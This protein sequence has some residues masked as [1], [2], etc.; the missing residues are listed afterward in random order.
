MGAGLIPSSAPDAENRPVLRFIAAREFGMLEPALDVLLPDTVPLA[1][2][3]TAP[4]Q[5]GGGDSAWKSATLE[6]GLEIQVPLFVAPG[7]SLLVD[8]KTHKYAGKAG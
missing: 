5:H 2:A 6:G 8:V 4:A 1:V 7:D 3:E